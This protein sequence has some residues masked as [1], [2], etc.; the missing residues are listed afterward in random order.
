MAFWLTGHGKLVRI[1][2]HLE[3]FA[4]SFFR[5]KVTYIALQK[6]GSKFLQKSVIFP[7]QQRLIPKKTL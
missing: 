1:T 2:I 7:L 4:A 6:R 5:V 3:E